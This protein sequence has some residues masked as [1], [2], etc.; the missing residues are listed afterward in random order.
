MDGER[1]DVAAGK[2]EGLDDEGIGRKG[3]PLASDVEDRPVVQLAELRVVERRD[4]ELV[5][6]PLRQPAAAAVREKTCG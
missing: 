5:D 2:E 1:P 6:Q 4:E 3:Q